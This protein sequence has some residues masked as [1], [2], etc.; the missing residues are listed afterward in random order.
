MHCV[1]VH[2][3]L[4]HSPKGPAARK[5]S[6]LSLVLRRSHVPGKELLLRRRQSQSLQMSCSIPRSFHSSNLPPFSHPPLDLVLHDHSFSS[7]L[8]GVGRAT[9]EKPF[10]G[11]DWLS[12]ARCAQLCIAR[13]F[14]RH[15]SIHPFLLNQILRLDPIVGRAS[16]FWR[17]PTL[18]DWTRDS[19]GDGWTDGTSFSQVVIVHSWMC[20]L[21]GAQ[22]PLTLRSQNKFPYPL[23][24]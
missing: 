14:A 17:Q 18:L 20:Q 12:R 11:G 7:S 2:S 24:K 22:D 16:L 23:L 10:T 13:G 15:T 21:G 5:E 9:L 1:T 3:A 4:R 6:L 8:Y 19:K